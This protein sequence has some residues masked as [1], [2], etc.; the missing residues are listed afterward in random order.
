M[1]HNGKR[2][3]Y[4]VLCFEARRWV[5]FSERG[6]DNKGQMVEMFQKAVDGRASGEPWCMAFVQFCLKMTDSLYDALTL[7]TNVSRSLL[8][9]SESVM[10][11]WQNAPHELKMKTPYRGSLIIWQYY[12]A[13]KPTWKGHVGI[14]VGMPEDEIITTIEGNTSGAGHVDREGDGVFEKKRNWKRDSLTMRC[15]GFLKPWG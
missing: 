12:S 2:I 9:E 4:N 13:G 14:V 11:V 6:G 5:G 7:Q 10:D 8:K 1:V 3:K 15:E